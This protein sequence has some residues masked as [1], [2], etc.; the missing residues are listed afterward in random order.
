MWK[1]VSPN[2]FL[3]DASKTRQNKSIHMLSQFGYKIIMIEKLG[4]NNEENVLITPGAG[5]FGLVPPWIS[6]AN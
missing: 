4:L 5:P 2:N 3:S 6:H 1:G